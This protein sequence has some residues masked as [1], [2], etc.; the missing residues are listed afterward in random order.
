MALQAACSRIIYEITHTHTLRR[1]AGN[2]YT[3]RQQAPTST[4]TDRCQHE[5]GECL[6]N[7]S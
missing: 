4:W 5:L 1:I 6:E 3:R 2:S 7:M